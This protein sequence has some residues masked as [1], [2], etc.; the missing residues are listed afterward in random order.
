MDENSPLLT[1]PTSL[2]GQDV[3][4]ASAR[5][6]T[7]AGEPEFNN[8]PFISFG[9]NAMTHLIID[10]D[11]EKACHAYHELVLHELRQRYWLV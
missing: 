8:E 9:E 4:R 6:T 1:L 3:M 11:H 5:A 7:V 2:D 10:R